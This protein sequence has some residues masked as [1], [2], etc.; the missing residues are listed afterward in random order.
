MYQLIIWSSDWRAEVRLPVAQ[1]SQAAEPISRAC[2]RGGGAG[3]VVA[4]CCYP[5]MQSSEAAGTT[6]VHTWFALIEVTALS[7]L[8]WGFGHKDVQVSWLADFPQAARGVTHTA[9]GEGAALPGGC[10]ALDQNGVFRTTWREL[11][12]TAGLGAIWLLFWMGEKEFS[13]GPGGL[14]G[15]LSPE[16]QAVFMI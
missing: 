1:S 5:L 8:P 13:T 2:A 10:V 6:P 4:G 16:A 3:E 15:A 7:R 12:F 11:D 9:A 14:R